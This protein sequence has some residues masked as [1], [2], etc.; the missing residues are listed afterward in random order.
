MTLFVNEVFA[1]VT[2]EGLEMSSVSLPVPSRE[3]KIRRQESF[4]AKTE[5]ALK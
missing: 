5:A 1:G 4:P 3:K 2:E